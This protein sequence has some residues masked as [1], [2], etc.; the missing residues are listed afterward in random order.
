MTGIGLLLRGSF[1]DHARQGVRVF[2]VTLGGRLFIPGAVSIQALLLMG[3]ILTGFATIRL[4]SLLDKGV[5]FTLGNAQFSVLNSIGHARYI[6]AVIFPIIGAWAF[7]FNIFRSY[8][9]WSGLVHWLMS[10]H[11]H[12]WL[13]WSRSRAAFL[14]EG[15]DI[16]ASLIGVAKIDYIFLTN[17]GIELP[18]F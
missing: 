11:R 12:R 18:T 15:R 3:N 7:T 2:R 9:C 17:V 10:G 6:F 1:I 14:W 13:N 5:P 8:W 4:C 16:S